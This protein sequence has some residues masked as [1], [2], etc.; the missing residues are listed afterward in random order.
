MIVTFTGDISIT[1][2]FLEKIKSNTEIFSTEIQSEL[3]HSS[4]VVGN[5]EGPTTT[6]KKTINNNTP[7]KSPTNTINY[8]TNR[9]ISI[10]NLANNHILDYAEQGLR[11]TLLEIKNGNC[12]YFGAELTKEKSIT[13]VIINKDNI[14]IAL[15]GIAKCNPAKI[16]NAQL[17][18]S[19]E[20]TLL[21]KQ[22]GLYKKKVDFIIVNFHGGEEYTHFPS[23]IKRKF[24]K[25]IAGLD[26]VDC[27]I[28]HHS[29]TLQGYEKHKNT[30]IFYSL[31]NFIFDI[32]NHK[33]HEKTDKSALLKLHFTKDKF[34]FRF[35]PFQ[36]KEGEILTSDL[37]IF[38]SEIKILSNFNDYQKKWQSEAYR[39]LFRKE[40]SKIESK[41]EKQS[42]QSTPFISLF[43]TKSFYAKIFTILKDKYQF[44]LYFNAII[45]RLKNKFN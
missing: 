18:S 28:A 45:Y 12:A 31:G 13:P 26:N 43:F 15:F 23:P 37:E 34:T 16:G 42:L 8:L 19:D 14:S 29:H 17:F 44:S 5:L 21:K 27:V 38:N 33:M 30:Y 35:V 3:I 25:K 40:N 1:G 2:S 6:F 36:I 39:V 32:P 9:N 22:I 20:F 24:L 7:L 41:K 11:D 10:Y 4:F